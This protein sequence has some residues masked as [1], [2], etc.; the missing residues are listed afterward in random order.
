MRL[1]VAI[2]ASLALSACVTAKLHTET[3]LNDVGRTCGLALGE[4]FQDDSEK[5]LLFLMKPGVTAEQRVCVARWARHNHLR[6]A[7]V[8]AINFPAS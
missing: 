5:R 6:L 4:L 1:V 3:E 7:V 8:E 2:C